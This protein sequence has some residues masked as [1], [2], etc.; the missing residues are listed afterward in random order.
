MPSP[1]TSFGDILSTT[2]RNYQTEMADNVTANIPLLSFLNKRGK[3]KPVSGGN[4]IFQQLAYA[5]NA[6][7]KAYSGFETL[8]TDL[9]EQFTTAEYDWKQYAV[10]VV[11][12][13]LEIDVQNAG[14]EQIVDLLEAR[15]ENAKRTMQNL[16]D[17]GLFSDGTLYSGKGITGLQAQV[18]D[19]PSTGTVGGIN[20][21]TWSFWRNTSY[22]AS[23]DGG[24]AASATN[25]QTYM[26]TVYNRVTR[27]ADK[28]NLIVAD[29]NY[30]A[31][32]QSSLQTIQRIT[33]A[34]SGNLGFTSLEYM[35]M[36][37]LLGGGQG[38]SCPTDRMYFLNT[39]YLFWRPSS[40]R[41]V[42]ALDTVNSINQ[43]AMVKHL[44]WAGNLTSSNLSLQAVLKA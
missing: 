29:S 30:Y 41:N 31:F 19:S 10:P 5:E 4:K 32:Y 16:L 13:G 43:D 28:P 23:S 18:A 20:R 8:N 24:A 3:V 15:V 17:E 33:N 6:N 9:N 11:A 40:R 39:N 36:P 2:L 35:G 22:D 7:G 44:V 25:I 1:N 37:V 38:G 21:A 14:E 42:V 34:E 27:N 12:S 26:N